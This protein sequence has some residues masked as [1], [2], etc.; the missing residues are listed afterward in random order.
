M[1]QC[2][3]YSIWGKGLSLTSLYRTK[4]FVLLSSELFIIWNV[5]RANGKQPKERNHCPSGLH[6]I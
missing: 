3:K 6:S 4:A 5:R 1:M 2:S